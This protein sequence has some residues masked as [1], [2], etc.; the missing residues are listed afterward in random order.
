MAKKKKP[1][2]GEEPAGPVLLSGGNPQIA[3]ADG[4]EAVQAYLAAMPGWK[5]RVGLQLDALV[6]QVV[7]GVVKAVR[8]NSPFFGVAGQGQFLA[9]HC[10]TKYVKVSFFQGESMTPVPPV[11]SKMPRVRYAHIFE[12]DVLDESLWKSW[13]R[14]AAELPGEKCF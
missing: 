9:F 8:W 2:A 13:I 5:Q 4:D 14:Q 12:A 1:A 6:T 7:P 3:K 10:I 11:A